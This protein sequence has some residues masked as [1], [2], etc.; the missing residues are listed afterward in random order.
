MVDTGSFRPDDRE[1][2]LPPST[3]YDSPKALLATFAH[4]PLPALS[5][6]QAIFRLAFRS[7]VRSDNGIF[8]PPFPSSSSNRRPPENEKGQA[9]DT[10][11]EAHRRKGFFPSE[12]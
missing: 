4:L 3:R 8:Y 10:G 1:I 5:S 11:K 12:R 2:V 9:A 7:A 6:V